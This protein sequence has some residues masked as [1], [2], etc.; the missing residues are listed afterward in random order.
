MRDERCASPVV[1]ARNSAGMNR[2][3]LNAGGAR[4]AQ[5][6]CAFAILV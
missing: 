1:H 2:T 4:T 5:F 3:A 6:L